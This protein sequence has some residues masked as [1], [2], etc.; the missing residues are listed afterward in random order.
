MQL[1][2]EETATILAALR[3]WQ[4]ITSDEGGN[5]P[6]E[7]SPE[8]FEDVDPLSEAEIDVLC[9]KI[10]LGENSKRMIAADDINEN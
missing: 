10:N 4:A 6:R 1:T 3:N 5:D 8:H 7:T 9:Q 2:K